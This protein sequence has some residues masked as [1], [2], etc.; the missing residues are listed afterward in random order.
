MS[1]WE[2][3]SSE[4]QPGWDPSPPEDEPAGN[5]SPGCLIVILV[6]IAFVFLC[7][8]CHGMVPFPF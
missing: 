2:H 1:H 4:D 7:H 5:K 8:K 3:K 6:I